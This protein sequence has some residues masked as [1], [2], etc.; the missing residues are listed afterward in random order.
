MKNMKE[1]TIEEPEAGESLNEG[2]LQ[3]EHDTVITELARFLKKWRRSY[4]GL[5]CTVILLV[6]D[7]EVRC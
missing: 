5:S 2:S 7:I 3:R 1:V 6:I 4:G